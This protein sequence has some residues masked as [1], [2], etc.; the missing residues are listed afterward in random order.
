[1]LVEELF[2]PEEAEINNALPRKPVCVDEIAAKT[3]RTHEEVSTILKRMAGKGLC[4]VFKA[5]GGV[6]YRGLPFMPGIFEFIF[7]GGKESEWEKIVARLIQTSERAYSK[8]KGVEKVFYPLTRVIPVDRTIRAGNTIHRSSQVVTCINQYDSIGVG[9]SD[10]RPGRQIARRRAPRDAHRSL[11][12]LHRSIYFLGERSRHPLHD[13]DFFT[14]ILPGL[15]FRSGACRNVYPLLA[16]SE[17][18]EYL[19][20]MFFLVF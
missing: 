3:A 17:G 13:H 4:G 15:C 14:G 1:L 12:V 10:C 11:H 20:N 19:L 5:S 6:F 18:L 16:V 2:D 7:I 9:A 8:A